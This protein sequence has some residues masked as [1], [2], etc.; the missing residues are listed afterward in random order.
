MFILGIFPR[1]TSLFFYSLIFLVDR[2][3]LGAW[4]RLNCWPTVN[5]QIEGYTRYE[6]P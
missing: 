3:H 5:Q 2:A 4:N 6:K 1:M